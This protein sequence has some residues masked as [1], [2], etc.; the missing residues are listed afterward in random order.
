MLFHVALGRCQCCESGLLVKSVRV[1]R[2]QYPS[3]QT[4]QCRMLHDALHQPFAQFASAMRLQHEYVAEICD[5]CE[6][7]NH[8]GESNLH[9]P[10]YFSR[11][12]CPMSRAETW[13]F[14]RRFIIN[15]EAQ[16]MLDRTCHQL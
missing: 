10:R 16:G 7:A 15:P 11:L 5:S 14:F 3:S 4:L 8:P 2:Q 9:R 1:T 6:I 13:G 12:G